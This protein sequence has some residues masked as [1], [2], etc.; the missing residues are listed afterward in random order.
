METTELAKESEYGVAS[1]GGKVSLQDL[2]GELTSTPAFG[3]LKKQLSAL[4]AGVCLL[5][6][7]LSQLKS[8][9]R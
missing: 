3:G 4:Q 5:C 1:R 6:L 9:W 2:M 7:S 8:P